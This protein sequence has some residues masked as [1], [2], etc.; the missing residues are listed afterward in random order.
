M[1][2]TMLDPNLATM[3]ED[4]SNL[5]HKNTSGL[6][7]VGR[8][9]LIK[10]YEIEF[11]SGTIAI[12]DHVRESQRVAEQR[13][14]VVQFGASAWADESQPRA[15]I[16]DHVLVTKYAGFEATGPADGESYRLVNDRDIFCRI[17]NLEE[18]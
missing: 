2:A 3:N 10:P 5:E 15:S 18:V 4:C 12:P 1:E 16:G 17:L 9:V 11:Q 7:A 13:A 6:E 8:A 14:V